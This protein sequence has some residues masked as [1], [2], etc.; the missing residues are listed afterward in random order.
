MAMMGST[1]RGNAQARQAPS[2]P[3]SRKYPLEAIAGWWFLRSRFSLYLENGYSRTSSMRAFPNKSKRISMM[4]SR[5]RAFPQ[6]TAARRFDNPGN[7]LDDNIW[8]IRLNE[9]ANI[10]YESPDADAGQR[11]KLLVAF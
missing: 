7:R 8:V 5:S 1:R 10:R 6:L 3:P 11:R 9:V 4:N 2:A